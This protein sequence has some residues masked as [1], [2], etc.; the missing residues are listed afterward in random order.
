MYDGRVRGFNVNG[1]IT[2][3]A[4]AAPG[5]YP[6]NVLKHD[7]YIASAIKEISTATRKIILFD[8]VSGAGVQETY[9]SQDVVEF[10]TKDANDI[11]CF[12]NDA[13]Q[14]K[15]EIYQ[16]STNGFWTP[17]TI[18]AGTIL[19]VARV[20]A[21]TYLIGHSNG[22]VYKYVYSLNSMTTHLSGVTASHICYDDV[23]QLIYVA[24]G[25]NVKRFN[26]ITGALVNTV[27]HSS[28]ILDLG[29]LYNK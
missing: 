5:W 15:M 22:T 4:M 12:G 24:E 13:G 9:L 11:I 6:R 10:Y 20:D 19:S 18:A 1:L 29:L 2:Y 21:G 14:G 8:A 27:T 3:N 23:N 7:Q 17:Y 25:N 26:Y 28:P 16:V